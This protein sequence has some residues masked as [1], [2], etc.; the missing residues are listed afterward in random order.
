M[1][2][3]TYICA[4][5]CEDLWVKL[6]FNLCFIVLIMLCSREKIGCLGSGSHVRI[7]LP[8]VK[9]LLFVVCVSVCDLKF[10]FSCVSAS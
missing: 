8:C 7:S 4:Y 2:V 9:L 5:I 3:C 1:Y 6:E 10:A